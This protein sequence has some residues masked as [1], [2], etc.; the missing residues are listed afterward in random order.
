MHKLPKSIPLEGEIMKYY[1]S[2]G[3]AHKHEINGQVFDRKVLLEVESYSRKEARAVV[4]ALFGTKWA[5]LYERAELSSI[6][7]HFSGGV[8]QIQLLISKGETS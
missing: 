2:F 4:V 8:V 5:F 1:I 3:Q 7:H 6:L